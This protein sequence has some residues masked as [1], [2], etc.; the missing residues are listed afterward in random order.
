MSVSVPMGACSEH[1]FSTTIKRNR[2]AGWASA[3]FNPP[4]FKLR[5]V[6]LCDASKL[7]V[8]RQKKNM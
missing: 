8:T 7:F 1:P 6:R 3:F 5:L 4:Q 2:H